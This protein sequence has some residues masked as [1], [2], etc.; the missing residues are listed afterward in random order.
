MKDCMKP[1]NEVER[2]FLEMHHPTSDVQDRLSPLKRLVYEKLA[3]LDR[4]WRL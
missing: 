4:G 3:S 2:V 1:R